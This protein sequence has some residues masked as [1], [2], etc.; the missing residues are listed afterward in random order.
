MIPDTGVVMGP[1][2]GPTRDRPGPG[3]FF[4]ARARIL[5]KG[6]GST[7]AWAR[8]F[9]KGLKNW[10]FYSVKIRGPSRLGLGSSSTFKARARPGLD[11]LGLDPSLYRGP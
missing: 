5:G 11:F 2:L 4:K 8:L 9:E 3:H 6:P 7:Q 1:S 10:R